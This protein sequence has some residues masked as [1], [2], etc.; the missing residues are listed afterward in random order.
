MKEFN[1][2]DIVMSI[3]LGILLLACIVGVGNMLLRLFLVSTWTDVF[4]GLLTLWLTMSVVYF[5][6][7]G[8][9]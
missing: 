4:T 1:V 8:G 3:P 2:L 5:I 7:K 9:S 6:I